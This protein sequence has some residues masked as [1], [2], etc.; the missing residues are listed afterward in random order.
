MSTIRRNLA[1]Q[2][3]A[4]HFRL[5]VPWLTVEFPERAPC[6]VDRCL[7]S[8]GVKVCTGHNSFLDQTVLEREL[9]AQGSSPQIRACDNAVNYQSTSAQVSSVSSSVD[10]PR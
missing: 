2:D 7:N 9:R 5:E 6:P 3:T 8:Q 4:I 10:G 1:K